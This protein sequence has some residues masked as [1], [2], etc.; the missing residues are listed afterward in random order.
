MNI[1]NLAPL[2]IACLAL[3]APRIMTSGNAFGGAIAP[4]DPPCTHKHLAHDCSG[5]TTCGSIPTT[6]ETNNNAEKLY[7]PGTTVIHCSNGMNNCSGSVR[8]GDNHCL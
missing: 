7:V 1:R 5:A 6:E 3:W 8:E 2:V 4:P